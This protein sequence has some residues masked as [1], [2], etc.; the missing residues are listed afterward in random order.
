MSGDD[1]KFPFHSDIPTGNT[2]PD[3]NIMKNNN[4]NINN[5]SGYA[6]SG[7]IML[8]A[9]VVLFFVVILMFSLH[10][11][12]RWYLLRARRRRQLRYVRRNSRGM[13]I[14]VLNDGPNW[15]AAS[16]RGLD[17][18]VLKSLPV[19]TFS[20]KTHPDTGLECAVCLSEFE[21]NE[22]GRV[23]PKCK[24][25]FHLQC[26]D[27]WF[28]SHSTCPL[29]RTPV[30][31]CIPGSENPGDVVLTINEPSGVESRSNQG[32]ELC[33]T[34]QNE[35]GRAGTSAIGSGRKLS[36]EVPARNIEGFEGESSGCDSGPSQTYRSPMSRMLSFKRILSRDRRGSSGGSACLSPINAGSCGPITVS[37]SDIERGG[38][39]RDSANSGL[40]R[41]GVTQ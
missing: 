39:E 35:E 38:E 40:T 20:A 28:H 37:E 9:I 23:L 27:M 41:M 5:N 22:A 30:E 7:K 32:S 25:S 8:S 6:L 10:L 26:I 3:N 33:A 14:V 34:C 2:P 11:Y 24:H 21:E 19:F 12:A 16:T 13:Q 18:R 1:G 29:C 36:I 17:A 4:N 15:I 31:E